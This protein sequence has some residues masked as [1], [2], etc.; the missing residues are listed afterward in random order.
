MSV[1]S[2]QS[3]ADFLMEMP[4]YSALVSPDSEMCCYDYSNDKYIIEIKDRGT[5]DY[6]DTM[7]EKGKWESL[8]EVHHQTGKIPLYVVK[9]RKGITIF[10]ASSVIDAEV[11][12]RWCPATSEFSNRA[13][14]LKDVYLID[15]KKGVTYGL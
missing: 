13:K 3:I 5:T 14:V 12:Q 15:F 8:I 7:L 11:Q 6:P 9:D 2:Q 10:N 1:A 4:E